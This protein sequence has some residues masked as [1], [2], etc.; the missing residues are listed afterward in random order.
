MLTVC[1]KMLIVQAVIIIHKPVDNV[2]KSVNNL[3][4]HTFLCG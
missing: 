4:F 3:I 2:N 1:Y